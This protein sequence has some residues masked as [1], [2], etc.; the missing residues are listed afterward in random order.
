MPD[1][2][3]AA[4][5][6]SSWPGYVAPGFERVREVFLENFRARGEIGAACAVELRGERVVDLW[7][8]VRDHTTG[9]PWEPDT[10]VIVFST[11][12]GMSGLA[13]AVAHSRGLFEY[14]ERVSAYW[15]E[16]SQHDKGSVTV[17][18]LLS[19][20]AGLPA[21][22]EPFDAAKLS[23]LDGVARALAAQRPAWEPGTKHGYHA[24]TIGWY[25]GELLRRVDPRRRTL[26]QF[27]ADEVAA[28]LGLDFTI[29]LPESVPSARV[30][31]VKGF[32]PT[33]LLLHMHTLP[34][35][36]VLSLLNP[37]SL[38]SRAFRN[39]RLPRP[40]D[41]DT[42]A[43]RRVEIPASNGYG[44]ARAIARAYGVFA[45]GGAELGL[46]KD[47]LDALARV[48][49]PPS[50]GSHDVILQIETKYSAGF[51]KPGPLCEFGTSD[52][53]YGTQGAGGS[54]GFADPDL[55][56]GF[57][58]VMNRMGFHVADDPREKALRD[59]TYACVRAKRAPAA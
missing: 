17:R 9:A 2:S 54:F 41:F 26:G 35:R 31:K 44:S 39:P 22:D 4:A 38:A 30:A 24:I 45:T 5:S 21:V 7:G 53:A 32:H 40:E 14:D 13:L 23:D 18:Q 57:G 37:R 25:E 3:G 6:I 12:K 8:G 16:F 42:P 48:A 1:S 27:F 11:T 43:L 55:G 28:P 59:A 51:M 36:F 15:P 50:D 46:R 58:Y 52:T 33:E 20:Q 34:P 29:G 19:H 56:L 10:R 47:T 49:T